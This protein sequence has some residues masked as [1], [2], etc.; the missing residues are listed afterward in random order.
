MTLRVPDPPEA[1]VAALHDSLAALAERG[2]FGVRRLRKARKEQLSAALPHQVFILGL[3]DAAEGA[4][5]RAAPSGWRYLL[6]ADEEVV[7]SGETRLEAGD[8]HTF[9]QINEGPFVRGTVRALAVA[10]KAANEQERD[11][12]FA[13]LHVPALYLMS[14]WLRP[15]ATGQSDQSLFIPIAPAPRGLEADAVYT[16]EAFSTR[17]AELAREVPRAAKDDPTGGA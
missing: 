12:E 9:S 8:R 6:E 1:S 7:A 14:V 15:D 17:I 2:Q 11:L 13:V 4:L 5:A 3:A 16:S 10:E